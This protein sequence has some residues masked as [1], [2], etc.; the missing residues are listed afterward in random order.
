MY[1]SLMRTSA[2][3]HAVFLALIPGLLL[4]Q[5]VAPDYVLGPGDQVQVQV[6]ELPE[7]NR[8]V[9]VATD[10]S[11]E[12][13]ILGTVPVEGLTLAELRARLTERL[14]ARGLR[15]PTVQTRLLVTRSRPVSVMGAI[16]RPGKRV[17]SAPTPLLQLILDA[18]GLAT[19]AGHEVIVQRRAEN[20]LSDKLTLSLRELLEEA[21]PDVDITI[22][23]G[24]LVRIPAA[25]DIVIHFQG[26]VSSPGTLTLSS[27]DRVTLLTA[28]AR[29][30]GLTETAA[31][32][33]RILRLTGEGD[34]REEIVVDYKDVV[35]GR[36]PDIALR[37]ED[38]IIVKESFF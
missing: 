25:R 5:D 6:V 7:L 8:D 21:D 19:N 31:R 34:Q 37:H 28:V 18:G 15:S 33:I 29:A 17:L 12:L 27:S 26:E 20:G 24:D 38:L 30:G 1:A 14:E 4:A 36:T 3:A 32:R 23:P 10:G 2:A 35:A 9:E 13:A 11:V 22:L 16:T